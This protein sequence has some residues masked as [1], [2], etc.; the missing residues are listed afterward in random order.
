[1]FLKPLNC[2]YI[3]NQLTNF[4]GVCCKKVASQMLYT[5]NQKNEN[6]IRLTSDSFCLIASHIIG[7]FFLQIW[8][9]FDPQFE[10]ILIKENSSVFT[11]RDIYTSFIQTDFQVHHSL[12]M[13]LW[14]YSLYIHYNFCLISS[15][16]VK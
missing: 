6:L 8:H 4:N 12:F 10:T 9:H 13:K 3:W 15:T 14:Q 7:F 2:L 11:P 1:M 16:G 5:I